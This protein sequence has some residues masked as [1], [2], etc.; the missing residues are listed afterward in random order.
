M[1]QRNDGGQQD[2][3]KGKKLGFI[4]LKSRILHNYSQKKIHFNVF[5]FLHFFLQSDFQLHHLSLSLICL[6]FFFLNLKNWF[7]FQKCSFSLIGRAPCLSHVGYRFESCNEQFSLLSF[8]FFFWFLFSLI[9]FSFSF[10]QFLVVFL[11]FLSHFPLTTHFQ[12]S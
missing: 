7:I 5:H 9:F 8:F 12:S 10:S 6:N 4:V 11:L 2:G 3:W 1:R